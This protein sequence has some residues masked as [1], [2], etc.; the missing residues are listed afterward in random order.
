[1]F[2]LCFLLDDTVWIFI[3]IVVTVCKPRFS[4][5][6]VFFKFSLEHRMQKC[7]TEERES[8]NLPCVFMRYELMSGETVTYRCHV[9]HKVMPLTHILVCYC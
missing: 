8:F 7:G 4:L 9:K 6:F 2:L 5:C 1:M 3:Y